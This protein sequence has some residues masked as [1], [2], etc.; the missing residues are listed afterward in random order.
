M[1]IK[2]IK[3]SALYLAAGLF[4]GLYMSMAH[5]YVLA[6]V[7]A[8]VNLLGWTTLTIAGILYYLFPEL[9]DHFLAKSHFWLHN[10]GLPLMMIG[11]VFAVSGN[12]SLLFLTIAG[13]FAV[14][15]GL[16]CFVWNVLV[17]LK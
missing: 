9:T 2:T 4:L 17:N 7:H 5:D 10:I 16:L 12:S 1:G 15:A 14:V 3:I 11:L 13:S 6:P 8:H